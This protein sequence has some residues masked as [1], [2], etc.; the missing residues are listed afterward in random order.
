MATEGGREAELRNELSGSVVGG[1]VQAGVVHGDVHFHHAPGPPV[2][3][4]LP[5]APAHFT[6]RD[7]ELS[8]LDAMSA[9]SARMLAVLC[10]P[11]G[12]GKTA[13]AVHWAYRD[14]ERFPDGQLYVDLGG[15]GGDEPVA[16][17]EALGLFLRGLGVPPERVPA[18]PVEQTALYRSLTADR[19]LL[20]VLDNAFSVAQVRPLLPAS[21]RSAVLV[22]SRSRLA[23]LVAEG[24]RLLDV[25]PLGVASAVKLLDLAVGGT[26]VAHEDAPARQLAVLCGGLPIA[27]RVAA[28]RL[29]A[30][31]RW[32]VG[33]VADELRD[34]RERLQMLSVSPDLSVRTTFD[35]SYRALRP[36]AAALYRRLSLHPGQDFGPAVAVSVLDDAEPAALDELVQGSLLEEVNEDRFRFHDLVRLHARDQAGADERASAL[37]RIAEWYLAAARVADLAVTPHRDRLP[38]RFTAEPA[39]LPALDR[40]TGLDWL[41]RERANLIAAGRVA[42]DRGWPDLAWQLADVVWPLLLHHKHY[43]DRFE[44]NERGIRAAREWGVPVAEAV[45]LRRQGMAHQAVGEF[46]EARRHYAASAERASAA[47]DLRGS[48]DAREALALLHLDRGEVREALAQF[49]ELVRTNRELGADRSLGLTLIH[50][51][52]VLGRVGRPARGLAALRE[53]ADLLDGLAE[54]DPYNRARVTVAEARLHQV[55]GDSARATELGTRALAVMRDLGSDRGAAEAHEVLAEA[56]GDPRRAAEH[57][58]HALDLLTRLGSRRAAEVSDRLRAVEPSTGDG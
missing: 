26:R 46:A 41:E 19:R 55:A 37:R 25:G 24:A 39:R 51:G 36:T 1:V 30:R 20:V 23:G 38:Y 48:A 4:Q 31:P 44:I 42:L 33:R 32:S 13:L 27:L 6:D 7:D 22:T 28:A 8:A 5:A 35:L 52:T 50:L 54:P 49:E 9:A 10:G 2:P 47:G 57:W 56:A 18:G 11:G 15:F 58:R 16:P 14:L 40:T 45:M 12:V 34:E 21:R 3:R 17:E 43:R 53:A 29:V